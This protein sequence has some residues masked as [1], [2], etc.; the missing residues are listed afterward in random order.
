MIQREPARRLPPQI[1]P[2]RLSSLRVGT[3]V[4]TC[5]TITD[6]I[7]LAGTDGRP[8]PDGNKSAKS[9]SVNNS[10]R[11]AARNANMLPAGTR[12]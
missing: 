3:V 8:R 7:T 11:C 1:T 10:P 12:C 6:A 2:G 9:S 5:S 4:R